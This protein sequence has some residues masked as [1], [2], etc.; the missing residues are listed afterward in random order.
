VREDREGGAC[1]PALE[2]GDHEADHE[3]PHALAE[4]VREVPVGTNMQAYTRS[5]PLL[6]DHNR[7]GRSTTG[8]HM[9]QNTEPRVSGVFTFSSMAFRLG[10]ATLENTPG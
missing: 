8:T 9:E 1:A 3:G 2:L 10:P 7:P 6:H 5:V 4:R